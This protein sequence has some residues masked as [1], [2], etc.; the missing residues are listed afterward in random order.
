MKLSNH[1][2]RLAYWGARHIILVTGSSDMHLNDSIGKEPR[3]THPPIV[4]AAKVGAGG[5]D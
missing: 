4:R 5:N 3:I 2:G 1:F